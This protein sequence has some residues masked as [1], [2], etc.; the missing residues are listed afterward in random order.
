MRSH[1]SAFSLS[2]VVLKP[3]NIL[4]ANDYQYLQL[5]VKQI[6]VENVK[7]VQN[8]PINVQDYNSPSLEIAHAGNMRKKMPHIYAAYMRY[9]FHQI[10]HIF[11]HILPQ[12]VRH[13][14][15]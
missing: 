7:T 6:E 10:P 11:P 15:R 13:I 3:L 12:K 1:L 4:V 14:S 9:I 8:R 5:D 2:N